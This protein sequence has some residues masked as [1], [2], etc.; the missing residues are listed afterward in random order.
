M[1]WVYLNLEDIFRE[2]TFRLKL[3]KTI[4]DENFERFI[5]QDNQIFVK[6]S[7]LRNIFV[8]RFKECSYW[9]E[10]LKSHIFGAVCLLLEFNFSKIKTKFELL[11]KVCLQRDDNIK[12]DFFWII[13]SS[14]RSFKYLRIWGAS[15]HL[16]RY[17]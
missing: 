12:I 6:T 16:S 17:E 4:V 14:R 7:Y 10:Y 9:K 1:C 2:F 3:R 13:W 11:N 15:L 8:Q 5:S